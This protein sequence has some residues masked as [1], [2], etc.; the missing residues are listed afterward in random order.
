MNFPDSI[1]LNDIAR[2]QLAPSSC[3]FLVE[4]PKLQ[5]G[6][7]WEPYKVIDLWDSILRGFPIGSMMVSSIDPEPNV[8]SDVQQNRYW[9]L[10]GQQRATS[11]AMGFY[12]PWRPEVHDPSIWSVKILPILWIDLL[13]KPQGNDQKMFFVNLVT[14]SHPWGY[15]NDGGIIS[16]PDRKDACEEFN[17]QADYTKADLKSCFPWLP[18][19]PVPL[20]FMI[21]LAKQSEGVDKAWATMISNCR[22]FLPEYWH[23]WY[24]KHLDERMP[25]AFV[26]I[27]RRLANLG[28]YKIHLNR[29]TSEA[30]DN[31]VYNSDDNSLLFVRLNTGGVLLGG[32]ELIF[33]LFKSAFP[34]AKDA[35][36]KCAAGF[37]TPSKLFGLL[38]RLAAA[39]IDPSRLARPMSLREFKREINGD[40]PLKLQLNELIHLRLE[41]LMKQAREIL[42]GTD[43]HAYAFCLPEAVATRTINGAPDIFLALLFWLDNG[44]TVNREKHRQLLGKFT[45]ISWFMPGNAKAKQE[46]L[47]KWI[48][49]AGTDVSGRLWSTECVRLLFTR[50]EIHAPIF[51]RPELLFSYLQCDQPDDIKHCDHYS[52][53]SPSGSVAQQFWNEYS[54]ISKDEGEPSELYIQRLESNF[55]SFLNK[56][57]GCNTMLL[58]AQRD[59]LRKR[60]K[61]FAQWEVTLNDTNCPWDWDH[62]Y[63][64]AYRIWSVYDVYK[65]WHNTIGNKRIE[66]LSENRSDGCSPPTVKLELAG[67]EGRLNSFVSPSIWEQMLDL[68]GKE[69][70]IKDP[71]SAA[72][73]CS[74]VLKRMVSIYEEWYTELHIGQFM[75]E[76]RNGANDVE[77]NA[78]TGPTTTVQITDPSNS[79][80]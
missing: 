53:N 12:N 31:D 66:G 59:Y 14:Q 60:F 16:V 69:T 22:D 8:N 73:I 3:D 64:S 6:F 30:A 24:K 76:I 78:S 45:A 11:I 42:C 57:R 58:Y 54:A 62:I 63:P 17:L 70:A 74:I 33:S 40:S 10:D 52:Y 4:L 29:L 34:S 39:R 41:G 19:F 68:K 28:D 21:D 51:P 26:S 36:E 50:K 80:A 49:E 7:V 13:G 46:V 61:A 27:V 23:K 44:G 1:T 56:L 18:N 37:M 79:P 75:E 20:S 72:K 15:K 77:Q 71:A 32:E 67:H 43:D 38:V 2:W 47:G 65:N 48:Q 5:R 35:V 25:E 55:R 9:L